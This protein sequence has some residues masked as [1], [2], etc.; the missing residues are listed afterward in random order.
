MSLLLLDTYE[1]D[2][3]AVVKL[4]DTIE[5]QAGRARARWFIAL[6]R[7]GF[8]DPAAT[9]D[10]ADRAHADFAALGDRWGA[11]AALSVRAEVFLYLG[12][13]DQARADAQQAKALFR[14]L[15]DGWGQVHA[16]YTLGDL[17]EMTGDYGAAEHLRREGHQLANDLELWNDASRMQAR[18]GRVALLTGDLDRAEDL[19]ERARRLAAAHGYQRGEEFAE[20]GMGLV[21]RRQGRLD[22]AETHLRAW[23]DWCR[24]WEGDHGVAFILAELGFIAEQRGDADTARKLHRE[25]LDHARRTG[26]P[27][28]IALAFEGLAGAEALAG[29]HTEAARLLG[30]ATAARDAVGMPLPTAERGDVDRITGIVRAGLPQEAYEYAFTQGAGTA[31]DGWCGRSQGRRETLT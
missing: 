11:A 12:R 19:H 4:Y 27:R 17:A 1:T 2:S 24:R 25:G 23:L 20:I 7:T 16:T 5:D 13:Q 6:G 14:E 10:L 21:A 8:G 15:G 26:D 18:L 9:L 30:A 22:D 29:A 28:A 3:Q 31:T